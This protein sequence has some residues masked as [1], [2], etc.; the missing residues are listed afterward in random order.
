M[1]EVIV[2]DT[3]PLVAWLCETDQWHDWSA[4][5]F[6]RLEPP[7]LTCEP[8]L[9]ETCFLYAREG[10]D[11]ARIVGK[12]REG[13]LQVPLQIEKE[14][15]ALE[16]LLERYA[17]MPMSLADACVVRLSELRKDCRVFTL[18]RHFKTYR[19]FGRSVIPTLSP[20]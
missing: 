17:D 10:G 13:L 5:H 1:K 16:T 11:P 4:E 7:F 6:G 15:G 2:L 19:R 20:W 9:T 14:A 8:V 12:V 3:G 18:D